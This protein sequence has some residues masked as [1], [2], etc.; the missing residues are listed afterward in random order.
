MK[1]ILLVSVLL[2]ILLTSLSAQTGR[3][4]M[5]NVIDAQKV[6]SSAMDIQMTLVDNDGDTSTRRIQ[7]LILNDNDLT[8]TITLFLEPASVRNTRFLT[9]E[10]DGR[11]D[12]QWIFLPSLRKVKRIAAGEKDGSF[13]GSDFSYSDMGSS[14]SSVEDSTQTVLREEKYN[15]RNSFVVESIPN[16]GTDNN[17]GKYITWVDKSSWLTLKVEF[18]SKDGKTQIKELNSENIV[19]ENSHWVA[20]KI[21]METL[22]SGHKTILEI[23]QVKYDIPL[24]PGYFTTT[25]LETGRAK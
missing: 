5:Q 6:N 11:A 19:K 4:I 13:M 24:N 15:G 8:K 3:E 17:Y 20:K 18:Y 21:T 1:K 14:G 2:L 22:E 7:T 25:F 12:D 23:K 10:N 16:A 9:V